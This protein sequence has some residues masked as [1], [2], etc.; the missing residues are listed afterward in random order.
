M[1]TDF[2][3]VNTYGKKVKLSDFLGK[4]V[5]LYFYPK[6]DTT[7]CTLEAKEFSELLN[8][9]DKINSVVIGISPDSVDSHKK[10]CDKYSLRVQLLSDID[11]KV[12]EQFG[13]WKEKNMYVH[14]TK[15]SDSDKTNSKNFLADGRKYMGVERSTFII[16]PKGELIKEY[17]NVK[18]SLH[19]KEVLAYL[20]SL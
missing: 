12:L 7:G 2:S 6:D 13:V 14:K 15:F 19:A 5:V 11:K 16:S 9:F 4:Y 1:V 18:A 8:Q 10:F 3:L 17:R 20:K